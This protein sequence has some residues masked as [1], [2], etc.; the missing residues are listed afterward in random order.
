MGDKAKALHPFPEYWAR[1][2][3]VKHFWSCFQESAPQ[4]YQAGWRK[5]EVPGV[6]AVTLLGEMS[7]K[8]NSWEES[9]LLVL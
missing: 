5:P 1:V 6:I 8:G 9:S 4:K 3:G 2:E 7:R